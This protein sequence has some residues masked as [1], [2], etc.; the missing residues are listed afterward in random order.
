MNRHFLLACW[1]WLRGLSPP[2]VNDINTFNH[3][4]FRHIKHETY[5]L[6]MV[7]KEQC[8]KCGLNKPITDFFKGETCI[9]GFYEICKSCRTNLL[10]L[11]Q[12]SFF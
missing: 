4:Y 11:E 9:E 12:K 7:L 8:K 1:I 5:L 2:C 10:I 6:F 3:V